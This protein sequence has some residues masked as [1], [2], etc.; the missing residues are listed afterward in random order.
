MADEAN[1]AENR[2][3]AE[4]EQREH[5]RSP[6]RTPSPGPSK[7]NSSRGGSGRDS[8]SSRS[9]SSSRSQKASKRSYSRSSSRSLSR[10]PASKRPGRSG[11]GSQR[12]SSAAGIARPQKTLFIGHL[13]HT[14]DQQ[15][16][17]AF[18]ARYGSVEESKVITDPETRRS[19]GYG[20][21]TFSTPEEADRVQ[22]EANGA[23]LDGRQIRVN[24]AHNSGKTG[25]LRGRSAYVGRR[26]NQERGRPFP[27]Y[28][29]RGA[30]RHSRTPP[31]V[32]E[33]EEHNRSRSR[34]RD[35]GEN[36]ARDNGYG[37]NGGGN[38]SSVSDQLM[39]EKQ[40]GAKLQ[41]RIKA[42][43][44]EVARAKTFRAD[45]EMRANMIDNE[46]VAVLQ[47]IKKR[48]DMLSRLCKAFG[49]VSRSKVCRCCLKI[50]EGR[51]GT[52]RQRIPSPQPFVWPTQAVLGQQCLALRAASG[53]E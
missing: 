48:R 18:F 19:R 44:S 2:E 30:G 51:G 10:S 29:D 20:F 47:K 5:N 36:A 27:A 24:L 3:V 50:R 13:S 17:G 12:H 49:R 41:E 11:E 37:A 23:Q 9:S 53:C 16:L 14:T 25:A 34:S 4:E 22:R 35:I 43:E 1:Q 26:F 15:S 6:S 33:K 46:L 28:G 39:E 32:V 38:H 52:V 31:R 7:S 42:L 21:V 45:A 40:A 8:P